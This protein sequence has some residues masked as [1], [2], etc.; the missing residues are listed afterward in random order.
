VPDGKLTWFTNGPSARQA[1]SESGADF[2]RPLSAVP[3]LAHHQ[4]HRHAF[5]SA[6]SLACVI[7]PLFGAQN[8][9]TAPTALTPG[10]AQNHF[11]PRPLGM[12]ATRRRPFE[13]GGPTLSSKISGA[14]IFTGTRTLTA[15]HPPAP[16]WV[17]RPARLPGRS[18]GP[19]TASAIP[20][21]A[22]AGGP[23]QTNRHQQ[24]PLRVS[25][26]CRVGSSQLFACRGS[27]VPQ[28]GRG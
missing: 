28:G 10:G 7:T 5:R 23:A 19:S 4:C 13:R 2:G 17:R 6:A 24:R 1:T 21:E 3:S 8:S 15:E 9:S 14:R 26:G 25:P 18:S 20:S 11:P 12:K 27:P 22:A 16:T